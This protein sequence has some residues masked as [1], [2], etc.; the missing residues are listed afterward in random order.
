MLSVVQVK[1]SLEKKHEGKKIKLT[2]D[3]N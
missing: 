2:L 1:K 3:F